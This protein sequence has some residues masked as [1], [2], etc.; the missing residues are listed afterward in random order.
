[1]K[2]YIFTITV[3]LL[4]GYFT[5]AFAQSTESAPFIKRAPAKNSQPQGQPAVTQPAKFVTAPVAGHEKKAVPASSKEVPNAPMI[6][7]ANT[8]AR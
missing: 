2:R 3:F 1:M 5:G 6:K 8:Q 7:R 4:A